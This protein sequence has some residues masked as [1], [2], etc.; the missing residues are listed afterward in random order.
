M[1]WCWGGVVEE[2]GLLYVARREDAGRLVEEGRGDESEFASYLRDREGRTRSWRVP[3]HVP[4][5]IATR[6]PPCRDA[7]RPRAPYPSFHG[8]SDPARR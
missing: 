5:V 2:R 1:K 3:L 6:T 4:R 7:L 8:C